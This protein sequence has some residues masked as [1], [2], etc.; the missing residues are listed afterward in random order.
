MQRTFSFE[1]HPG[2]LFSQFQ[3]QDFEDEVD[4]MIMRHA[5][6]LWGVYRSRLKVALKKCDND[7]QRIIY[8]WGVG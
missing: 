3:K 6:H 1:P 4:E 2:V 7:A 8:R 5:E